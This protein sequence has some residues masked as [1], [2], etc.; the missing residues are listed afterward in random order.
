M[1]KLKQVR[2]QKEEVKKQN[3]SRQFIVVI[4]DWRVINQTNLDEE[5]EMAA[6]GGR[7]SCVEGLRKAW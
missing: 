1:T 2:I 4:R 3:L 7:R 6:R 5:A